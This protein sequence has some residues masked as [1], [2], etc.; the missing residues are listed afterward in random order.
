MS[1]EDETNLIEWL[2]KQPAPDYSGPQPS[3]EWWRFNTLLRDAY[4]RRR[5][6]ASKSEEEKLAASK[7]Y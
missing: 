6:K 1:V 4:W 7:V 2:S 5:M 3:T